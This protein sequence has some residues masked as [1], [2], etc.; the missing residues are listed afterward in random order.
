MTKLKYPLLKTTCQ[1]LIFSLMLI[2]SSS[3]A[4]SK[5]YKSSDV[6]KIKNL[7]TKLKRRKI[8]YKFSKSKESKL[9]YQLLLKD[10]KRYRNLKIRRDGRTIYKN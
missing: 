7:I 6:D 3:K 2:T 10:Y 5:T 1:S 8:P 9:Q 4:F